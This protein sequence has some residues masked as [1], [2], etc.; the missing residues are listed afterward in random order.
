M[1]RQ[2]TSNGHCSTRPRNCAARPHPYARSIVCRSRRR[3]VSGLQLR[4]DGIYWNLN[5]KPASNRAY[6]HYVLDNRRYYPV[7]WSPEGWRLQNANNPYGFY[8]PRLQHKSPRD[9]RWTLHHP[10]Q[11]PALLAQAGRL[12]VL[13]DQIARDETLQKKM[14]DA[15]PIWTGSP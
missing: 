15:L 13:P 1:R 14:F 8:Q 6:R 2:S 12:Q 11:E 10:E 3:L 5:R 9:N 7:C 4:D